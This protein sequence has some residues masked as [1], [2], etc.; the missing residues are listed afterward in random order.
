LPEQR[1]GTPCGHVEVDVVQHRTRALLVETGML[2]GGE[3]LLASVGRVRR[4]GT[5][6]SQLVVG[7]LVAQ[8]HPPQLHVPVAGGQRGR[9][10]ALDEAGL[11][12]EHL[13][14]ACARG[15]GALGEVER[16]AERAHRA[17]QH[18]HV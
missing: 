4:R 8:R 11:A 5:D 3:C 16:H 18:V 2:A 7:I 13:E 6:P 10:G 12:V 14:D 15:G 9:A 17:D 1:D